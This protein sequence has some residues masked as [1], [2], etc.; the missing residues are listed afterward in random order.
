MQG[1]AA[2]GH[3]EGHHWHNQ[4]Y[5]SLGGVTLSRSVTITSHCT[6]SHCMAKIHLTSPE[7]T[8]TAQVIVPGLA[9]AFADT[10]F[11]HKLN[12]KLLDVFEG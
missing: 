8:T 9:C 1:A 3:G 5:T 12:L 2:A 11:M 4:T 7:G 6:A 10:A